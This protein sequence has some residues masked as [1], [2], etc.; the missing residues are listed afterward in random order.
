MVYSVI[1]FI[2]AIKRFSNSSFVYSN[3]LHSVMPNTS[4]FWLKIIVYWKI[5]NLGIEFFER[6]SET[7]YR[8]KEIKQIW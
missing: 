8:K 3:S 6:S 1:K 4:C 7:E 5:M 2:L